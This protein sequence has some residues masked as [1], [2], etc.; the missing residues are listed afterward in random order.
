MLFYIVLLKQLQTGLH[1]CE[2]MKQNWENKNNVIELFICTVLTQ[3]LQQSQNKQ[4]NKKKQQYT[5]V[6][7]NNAYL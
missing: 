1:S 7:Q 5:H 3:W 6:G 4:E 2:T